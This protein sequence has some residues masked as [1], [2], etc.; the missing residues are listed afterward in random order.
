MIGGHRSKNGRAAHTQ[1]ERAVDD[2]DGPGRVHVVDV[3]TPG[4]CVG[5][6]KGLVQGRTWI[7]LFV[8]DEVPARR[9]TDVVEKRALGRGRRLR[10][11]D[12][13]G[14]ALY[15]ERDTGKEGATVSVERGRRI[16]AGVVGVEGPR[17][18]DDRMAVGITPRRCK[19]FGVVEP[20]P[21]RRQQVTPVHAVVGGPVDAALVEADPAVILAGN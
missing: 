12:Q 16:A 18:G 17:D 4:K 21:E 10:C 8:H 7:V 11:I 9:P 14:V 15:V 3:A 6:D 5:D 13:V 1:T 19:R 20:L 2:K